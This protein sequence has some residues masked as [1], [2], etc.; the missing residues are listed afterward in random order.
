MLLDIPFVEGSIDQEMDAET[1]AWFQ[2]WELP[3]GI[4]LSYI[5]PA[6]VFSLCLLQGDT[7]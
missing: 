3:P 6:G 1:G 5:P 7:R 4:T 2:W